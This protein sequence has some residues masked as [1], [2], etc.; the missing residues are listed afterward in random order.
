MNEPYKILDSK[1]VFNGKIIDVIQDKITLPDGN[2][3]LREVVL[4][5]DAVAIVPIDSNNNVTLVKQ[6]RHPAGK[7]LFE[8]P[9]GMLEK[10]EDP[11]QAGI[12]ELEEETSLIAQ[13][14]THLTTIYPAVGFCTEKIYIYLAK[15]LKQGKFNLDFDEFITT[16][17]YSIDEAIDMI[18]RGEIVDSKTI[19]GLFI[20]RKFL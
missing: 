20:C 1:K 5:G 3:S 19:A 11:I 16:Y 10:G 17:K 15:N 7:E 6:Y 12:R 14:L 13:D 9:A 2:T 4:R 18:Y 8:I